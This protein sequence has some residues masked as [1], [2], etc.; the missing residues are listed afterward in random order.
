MSLK[1]YETT[2]YIRKECSRQAEKWTVSPWEWAAADA[3]EADWAAAEAEAWAAEEAE[4]AEWAEAVA[5]EED[6]LAAVAEAH[7]EAAAAEAAAAEAAVRDVAAPRHG[8]RGRRLLLDDEEEDEAPADGQGG[9]A[10]GLRVAVIGGGAFHSF[11][12]PLQLKTASTSESQ[13]F[14]PMLMCPGHSSM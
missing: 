4:E 14:Q 9:E 10:C 3:E 7:E 1:L 8:H 13:S 11:P 6:R 2:Q 12:F 5:E